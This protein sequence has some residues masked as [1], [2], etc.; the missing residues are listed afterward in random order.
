MTF[1]LHTHTTAS[2]GSLAPAELLQLAQARGV[3]VLAITDHDTLAGYFSAQ[4]WL[5]ANEAENNE[6]TLIPGVEVST[7][8]GR[9]GIHV[10]GLNVNPHNAQL[11]ELLSTQQQLRAER[12][13]RIM[14]KLEKLG[15]PGVAQHVKERID[16][17]TQIGRP[18]I[19]A[20]LVA[21]QFVDSA[22]KAFKKYLGNGKP[23]DVSIDWSTLEAVIAA[24]NA[25]GGVAVLAHPAKYKM[26]SSKQRALL[27]DFVRLG[28]RG[29][30][31]IS[32]AQM[33]DTTKKLARLAQKFDLLVSCGSDF[34]S[35]DARWQS[36]GNL[37]T[38]PE[39]CNAVWQDWASAQIR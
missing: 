5:A 21:L 23:A 2:D 34:H 27:K 13:D 11:T 36:L 19:A 4:H 30:E 39:F 16:A 28:G 1:D 22:E 37:S 8:W 31:V 12:A 35:A 14:R 15:M 25:A 24:I 10:L 6:L 32:G 7:Q 38:I 26:T 17:A 20:S 29:I 3:T 9:Q 33:P 18:H